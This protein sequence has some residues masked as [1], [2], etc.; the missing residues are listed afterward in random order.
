MNK[1]L[2][3]WAIIIIVIVASYVAIF[4]IGRSTVKPPQPKV[5][6]TEK[7]KYDTTTVIRKVFVNKIQYIPR[8][9]STRIY[10]DSIVGKQNEVDYKIKHTVKDS[11][12]V[13]LPS[14]W[15]VAIEPHLTT[16]TKVITRDSIE[17]KINNVYL[18]KPFL[19]N[20]Y[21]W[22]TVGLAFLFAL[23]LIFGH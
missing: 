6:V 18:P 4:F 16:I 13:V 2:V 17:T 10:V 22:T 11:N 14:I 5:V 21:F 12:K 3:L 19:L 23:K 15:E 8:K 20:E 1:N 9:D 7:V